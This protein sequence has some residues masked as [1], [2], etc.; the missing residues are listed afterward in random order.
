MSTDNIALGALDAAA[1][2][3][4]APGPSDARAPVDGVLN[5]R[6]Q[7]WTMEYVQ[8]LVRLGYLD[9]SAVQLVQDQRDPPT[10]GIMLRREENSSGDGSAPGS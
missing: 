3:V 7:E 6:C 1:L 9:S 4:P 10:H 5:R 2:Q 8:H